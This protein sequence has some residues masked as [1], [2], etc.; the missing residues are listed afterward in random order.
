MEKTTLQETTYCDFNHPDILALAKKLAEH[1]PD[2]E[3]IT[4]ATFKYVRDNIRF[5]C[6]LVQVKASETLA[7]GYGPCWSK[8]LLLVALLRSNKIPSRMAFNLVKRD[9][10]RPA[11]GEAC[12][13]LHE[14]EKHCFALVQLNEKWVAVDATLDT[15]TYQK[16]FIPHNVAWGIDWDGKEDMR[17][18]TESIVGPIEF[19]EDIDA[20]IREDVGYVMPQTSEAD[21]F[22]K[23]INQQM[24]QD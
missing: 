9:F 10:M 14:T 1:G 2:P 20:A 11:M 8:A 13:T 19:F 24:W 5:G 17:L 6:D 7:K 22:F 16:F 21:A 3:K 18:Y 4:K 23:P 12:E 15:R